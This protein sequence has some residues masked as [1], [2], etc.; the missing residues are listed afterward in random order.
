MEEPGIAVPRAEFSPHVAVVAEL[1]Q[2]GTPA[3]AFASR[4]AHGLA[5]QPT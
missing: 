5:P 1:C 4:A 2:S 3:S